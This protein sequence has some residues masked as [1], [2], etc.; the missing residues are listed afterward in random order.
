MSKYETQNLSSPFPH[1]TKPQPGNNIKTWVII[2]RN[3][4]VKWEGEKEGNGRRSIVYEFIEAAYGYL[5]YSYESYA[6]QCMVNHIDIN[7]KH[8]TIFFGINLTDL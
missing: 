4:V 6:L 5:L 8:I 1:Q 2:S 7:V 3:V